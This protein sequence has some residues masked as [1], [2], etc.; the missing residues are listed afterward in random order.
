[1]DA[2]ISIAE[3][4]QL[5]LIEDAAESLGALWKGKGIGAPTR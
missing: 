4:Y 1:M 3:T 5:P 2:L